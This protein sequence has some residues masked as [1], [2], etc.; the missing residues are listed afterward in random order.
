MLRN[1][2]ELIDR[3]IEEKEDNPKKKEKQKE[4]EPKQNSPMVK[5]Y[6]PLVAFLRRLTQQQL[7]T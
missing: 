4:E 6:V 2:K 3:K 5:S 7:D 1:G